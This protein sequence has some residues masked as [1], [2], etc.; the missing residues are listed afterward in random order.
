MTYP[1]LP[2][3]E[4]ELIEGADLKYCG[5]CHQLT[6]QT[7]DEIL[8]VYAEGKISEVVIRCLCCDESRIELIPN[9]SDTELA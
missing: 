3:E 1:P 2:A 5:E 6:L 8:D 7:V 4:L 9:E